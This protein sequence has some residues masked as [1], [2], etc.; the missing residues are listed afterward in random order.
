MPKLQEAN[1]QQEVNKQNKERPTATAATTIPLI[2][3]KRDRKKER[4]EN[5][6]L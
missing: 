4:Q 2:N 3:I 6:N 1:H 5:T